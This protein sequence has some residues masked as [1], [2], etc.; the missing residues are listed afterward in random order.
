VGAGD[1]CFEA[2][3]TSPEEILGGVERGLYVTD[4]IGFGVDLVSGDYSQA[5]SAIGSRRGAWHIRSTRSRS[6]AT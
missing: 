1:L 5:L 4:L 6:P 3:E 2:G